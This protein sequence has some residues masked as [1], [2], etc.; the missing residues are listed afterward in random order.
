MLWNSTEGVDEDIKWLDNESERVGYPTQK[1]LGLLS[2]IIESS[3][4]EG[5]IVLDPF[6]GCATAPVAAERLNRQWVGIDL[7]TKAIDLVKLRLDGLL[8]DALPPRHGDSQNRHPETDGRWQ[9]TAVQDAPP[10][11]LRQ[12]GGP[13]RRL[14][15][16]LPVP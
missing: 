1:P 5:D 2:R 11:P 14:Q 3:S 8:E 7:S 9:T 6:C 16:P 10:H 12:A 15:S 13:M 4:N